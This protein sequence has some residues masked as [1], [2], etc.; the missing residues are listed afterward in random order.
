MFDSANDISRIA[1]SFETEQW[2]PESK[3]ETENDCSTRPKHTELLAQKHR[4]RSGAC[5]SESSSRRDEAA[6]S[7]YLVLKFEGKITALPSAP[8]RKTARRR[9]FFNIIYMLSRYLFSYNESMKKVLES[10]L[11]AQC[12]SSWGRR[13][14]THSGV[15]TA[16]K[17][18]NEGNFSWKG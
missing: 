10:F 11:K 7:E 4:E 8:R 17:Y 15:T 5:A 16:T 12:R 18:F 6:G 1:Q 14:R 13:R 3:P 9:V 2:G